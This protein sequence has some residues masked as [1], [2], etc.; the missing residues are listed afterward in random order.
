MGKRDKIR[1]SLLALFFSVLSP[2]VQG[3]AAYG[4]DVV[5]VQSAA[6]PIHKSILSGIE[7]VI[8][9]KAVI[10]N[11]D[12]FRSKFRSKPALYIAIGPDALS[13]VRDQGVPV[14]FS[15]VMNP[16]TLELDGKHVTGVE[17]FVSAG[18]QFDQ[19]KE[20]LPKA[21]K[22]G[23]VYA[24]H[25]TGHI[26]ER[27]K[28][29]ARKRGLTLVSRAVRSADEAIAAMDSLTGVDVFW[30][31]PDTIVLTQE[32]VKHLLLLSLERKIPVYALSEKY[33]KNGALFALAIDP[34][35]LGRQVGEMANR[36]LSGESTG[37]IPV[38]PIRDGNLYINTSVANRLRI[39][40][41]RSV[42]G[43]AYLYKAGE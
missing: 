39:D 5:V 35:S 41:P 4:A 6:T 19:L 32:T 27:A 8:K 16:D 25:A 11:V 33:V 3:T 10:A 26:V 7:S 24:P 23:V 21:T 30:M 1:H 17:L 31:V 37:S 36:V 15:M 14:V 20:V 18:R 42:L 29:A 9:E 34:H 13:A 2:L 43:R 28:E 40:I 12:E 22:I 38:E